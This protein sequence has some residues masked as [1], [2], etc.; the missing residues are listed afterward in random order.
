MELY[1]TFRLLHDHRACVDSYRRMGKNPA[2][3]GQGPKRPSFAKK[4][5]SQ[6]D[7][8]RPAPARGSDTDLVLTAPE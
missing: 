2:R 5:D 4:P 6:A 1:T 7:S 8:A 3:A